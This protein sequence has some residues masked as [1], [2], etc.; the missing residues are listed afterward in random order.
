MRKVWEVQQN[1]FEL[2]LDLAL[3]RFA[4][5]D[6]IAE[7]AQLIALRL[8]LVRLLVGD[9]GHCLTGLVA[10]LPQG[11]DARDHRTALFGQGPEPV[12]QLCIGEATASQGRL[13]VSQVF[14][15]H[16]GGRA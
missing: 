15:H 5:L 9:L 1:R 11:L 6:L 16:G 2:R 7:R 8:E 14:A 4:L 10:L 12:E 3:S 13:H